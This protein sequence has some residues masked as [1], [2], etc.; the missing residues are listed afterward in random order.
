MKASTTDRF[1]G[2]SSAA[3]WAER[4]TPYRLDLGALMGLY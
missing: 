2:V 4:F 1:N 3:Q